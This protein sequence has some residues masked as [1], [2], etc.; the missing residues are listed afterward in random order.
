M[1]S[2]FENAD[3]LNNADESPGVVIDCSNSGSLESEKKR[4]ITSI[5]DEISGQMPPISATIAKNT[6]SVR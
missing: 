1:I 2:E 4:K 5:K 6:I 3:V